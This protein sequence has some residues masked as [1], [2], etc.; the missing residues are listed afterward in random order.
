MKKLICI[1]LQ[2]TGTRSFTEAARILG[3]KPAFHWGG[4]QIGNANFKLLRELI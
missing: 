3:F 2:K 4:R 1:G